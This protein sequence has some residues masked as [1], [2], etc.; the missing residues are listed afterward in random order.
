MVFGDDGSHSMGTVPGNKIRKYKMKSFGK[1]EPWWLSSVTSK[2]TEHRIV[3]CTFLNSPIVTLR[4]Y[5]STFV[6]LF[7]CFGNVY[8]NNV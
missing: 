2:V 8:L 5:S 4:V 6:R 7:V 1:F 3:G